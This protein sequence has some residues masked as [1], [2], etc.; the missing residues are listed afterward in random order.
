MVVE[1]YYLFLML[2]IYAFQIA[3]SFL[4]MF[5]IVFK[6]LIHYFSIFQFIWSYRNFLRRR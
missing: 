5:Q 4:A 6:F 2:C 3:L 1:F